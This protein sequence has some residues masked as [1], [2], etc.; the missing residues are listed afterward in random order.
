MDD[1]SVQRYGGYRGEAVKTVAIG[2]F[3]P[4]PDILGGASIPPAPAIKLLNYRT[5]ALAGIFFLFQNH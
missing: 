3:G 1:A 4:I 5:M 2:K